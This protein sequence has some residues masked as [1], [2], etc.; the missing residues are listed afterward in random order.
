[1]PPEY[2]DRYIRSGYRKPGLTFLECLQS[3]F[4]WNNEVLNVWTHY[5]TLLFFTWKFCNL[6]RDL[7]QPEYY[8]LLAYAIGACMF[9]LLSC[10]AH[11]FS[12]MSISVRHICFFC[13]YAGISLYSI[14]SSVAYFFY[15]IPPDVKSTWLG[16]AYPPLNVLMAASCCYVCCISRA[17]QWSKYQTVMR[18]CSF[19][20]PY[21]FCSSFILH[22]LLISRNSPSSSWFHCSQFFWCTLMAIAMTT[23]VPEKYFMEYFDIVGHSHQWFHIFVSVGTNQQINA[24]LLDMIDLENTGQLPL[25]SFLSSVGLVLLVALVD[26]AIVVYFSRKI[27]QKK[28][29]PS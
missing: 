3:L 5:I 7:S 12:S 18:A 29:K 23:K 14:G 1:I 8:P 27:L 13:D 10:I 9:P 25:V 24:V 19:A 16:W 4:H 17:K 20:V 28:I 2:R 26:T 6:G 11:T 22:K 15:T 21:V